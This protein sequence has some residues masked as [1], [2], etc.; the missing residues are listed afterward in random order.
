MPLRFQR[1]YPHKEPWQTQQTEKEL[2]IWG[3]KSSWN[4][5]WLDHAM[6]GLK[7]IIIIIWKKNNNTINIHQFSWSNIYLFIFKKKFEI[8]FV[9]FKWGRGTEGCIF[10]G[11]DIPRHGMADNIKI[12]ILGV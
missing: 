1:I 12:T 10:M 11:S 7:K 2:A 9:G 6:I 8:S 3:E 4:C 5:T